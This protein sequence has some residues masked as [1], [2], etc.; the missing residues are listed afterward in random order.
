MTIF[1]LAQQNS[2]KCHD[3]SNQEL[4]SKWLDFFKLARHHVDYLNWSDSI[5]YYQQA[6]H[7]SAHMMVISNNH[8]SV[9]NQYIMLLLECA[10]CFRKK[11]ESFDKSNFIN[12]S[13]HLL[14]VHLNECEAKKI[15][16]PII[17]ILY[18]DIK[19]CDQWIAHLF[20]LDNKPIFH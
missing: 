16:T 13:F 9:K 6:L 17:D 5:Y 19:K 18:S 8:E 12:L 10:Y 2:C 1:N 3:F 11:D 20:L 4:K 15:L 14:K 7:L